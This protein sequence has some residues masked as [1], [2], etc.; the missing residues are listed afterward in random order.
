MTRI[1]ITYVGDWFQPVRADGLKGSDFDVFDTGVP[2]PDPQWAEHTELVVHYQGEPV[3]YLH[4]GDIHT[5]TGYTQAQV[6]AQ[7]DQLLAYFAFDRE[8]RLFAD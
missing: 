5:L 8:R 4:E 1:E 3:R 2:H 7:R 6:V